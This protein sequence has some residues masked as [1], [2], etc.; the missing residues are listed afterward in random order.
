MLFTKGIFITKSM[1]IDEMVISQ[2]I[3]AR[4]IEEGHLE[5]HIK[6]ILEHGVHVYPVKI[7][8]IKKEF[9]LNKIIM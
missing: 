9:H 5:R 2:L 6:K 7:H 8:T 3:L 4:F 1:L